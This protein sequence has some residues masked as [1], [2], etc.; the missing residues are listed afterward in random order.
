MKR[1]LL[2][3]GCVVFLILFL[4]LLPLISALGAGAVANAFDCQLEEGSI[5]P[6]QAFGRDLGETLYTF[7]MLGW[8]GIATLPLGLGALVLYGVIV[9]VFLLVRRIRRG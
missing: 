3:H 8:L 7:G 1:A 9:A 2:F 6:C 5:H 4:A